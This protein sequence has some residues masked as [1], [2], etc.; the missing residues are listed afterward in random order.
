MQ[1][2][3]RFSDF[4]N[5]RIVMDNPIGKFAFNIGHPAHIHQPRIPII[6]DELDSGG[7]CPITG[8]LSALV[9]CV[10]DTLLTAYRSK[11]LKIDPTC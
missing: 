2:Q 1:G 7:K 4:D 8:E 11:Q 9:Q 6:V 10:I 3:I 5:N